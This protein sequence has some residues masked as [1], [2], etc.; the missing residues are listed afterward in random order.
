VGTPT[1]NEEP[2]RLIDPAPL[3]RLLAGFTDV[4]D[5]RDPKVGVLT[6]SCFLLFLFL[7]LFA[8]LRARYGDLVS[9]MLGE[10]DAFAAEAIALSVLTSDRVLASFITLLQ[11]ASDRYTASAFRFRLIFL[12]CPGK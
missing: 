1:I 2:N 10:I 8:H 6:P 7:V 5:I 3:S 12:C 4:L 11:A 9:D